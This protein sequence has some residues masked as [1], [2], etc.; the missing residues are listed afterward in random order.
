M[1]VLFVSQCSKRALIETRRI[2]DQ[3]AERKGSR[4]WQ[5]SITQQGLITLRKMLRRTAR[6]NTAVAC[7][8]IKMGNRA[9]LLWIVGNIRKFNEVGTVPTNATRRNILRSKDEN[10]WH[11][12][13]TIGLISSI[14]GLFHD[15]GKINALFQNKLKNNERTSEPYRHEWISLRLFQAFVGELSD[16]EWLEKLHDL[17]KMWVLKH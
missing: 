10:L 9:E 12:I 2:L 16:R 4:T 6:R 1:N 5:T 15:F 17:K 14:T 7:H 11:S 13:E 8:W 3:F